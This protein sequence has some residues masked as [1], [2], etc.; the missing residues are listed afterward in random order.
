[1]VE[2]TISD[3]VCLLAWNVCNKRY[4]S[5]TGSLRCQ[6]TTGYWQW[7]EPHGHSD[8]G[9]TFQSKITGYLQTYYGIF[10]QHTAPLNDC[11][12]HAKVL[13]L[14]TLVLWKISLVFFYILYNSDDE[15]VYVVFMPGK[16]KKIP[17]GNIGAWAGGCNHGNK[18]RACEL[19]QT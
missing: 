19:L 17:V 9:H 18:A 11:N 2:S 4:F 5:P 6:N 14:F 3:P 15:V 16:C 1:M 10:I 8:T 7:A 12:Y 13:L